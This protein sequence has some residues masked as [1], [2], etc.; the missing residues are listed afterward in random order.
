[1]WVCAVG[2]KVYLYLGTVGGSQLVNDE[3]Y[4]IG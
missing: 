3:L 4:A 1:M 2:F